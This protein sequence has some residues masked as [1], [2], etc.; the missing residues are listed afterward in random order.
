MD[1]NSSIEKSEP[2][3]VLLESSELL[4]AVGNNV[5]LKFLITNPAPQGDYFKFTLLGI[6]PSWI[7]YPDTPAIWVPAEGHEKVSIS[8]HP[9][10]SIETTPGIYPCR[11]HVFSQSAPEKGV[12]LEVKLHVLQ[13]EKPQTVITIR[14]EITELKAAPGTGVKIP[15][16][17]KNL[18]KLTELMEIS[19]HGVPASWV[20]LLSPV[21]TLYGGEEK[22][23]DVTL[24]IP[25]TPEI[26]PGY[27]PLK[28]TVTSQKD[29]TVRADAGVKLGIAA[30]ESHGRIGVMLNSIQFSLMPGGILT[31]PITLL[32]HGLERDSFRLGV[33]GLPVSWVSIS[34]PVISLE[35][36][37]NKESNLVIRPP[38]SASIQAGRNKFQIIVSSQKAPDQIVRVDCTLTVAAYMKF[39]AELEP[40]EADAS[41]LI[42]VNVKNQGN[43]QQVFNIS[44]LSQNDQLVFEFQPPLK[45]VAPGAVG[46]LNNNIPSGSQPGTRENSQANP[47]QRTAGGQG[48]EYNVLR[49]PAGDS[50]A[51]RFTAR[52]R[53]RPWFGGSV[54]YPYQVRVKSQQGEAPPMPGQVNS[55]GIIPIWILP[56][57]AVLC[58]VIFIATIFGFR[59]GAKTGS[60]TQT[61]AAEST[62][63]AGVTQTIAANQ[64][65]AAIAGQLDTDGDGLTDQRETQLNTN[66][67]NPDTDGDRSWDG[68]EVQIGT[69]P[70]IPDTDADGLLDGL[71]ILPC[72]S[73]LNPDT[74]QDGIIDSKDL[75][76]CDANN[77]A[78]TA[79]A[80][81]LLPTNTPIPTTAIPTQTP[82]ILTPSPTS[83]S[84]PRFGGVILFESDR[85]GNSEVYTLDDS[86]HVGR[87]TDN[88]AA[89]TQAVW[90]ASMQRIAFTTNRDGQNEIYLMNA[91]G[92][93][94]VNLTNNPADDQQPAWSVDGQWIA[95]T[96]NRDG[97]YEIYIL[98]VSDLGTT[99]LSNHPG[100][101]SQPNW[102][103]STTFDPSGEY[104]LFS[105]DR[106]GNL[107]I[108]RMK[109]DGSE[110]VNLSV[111]PAGDQMAKGSPDGALVVFSSDRDGN[112]EV[113]SMRI[114]G[115]GQ[116]NQTNYF[117]YDYQPSWAPNQAW[118]AFTTN[119]DGNNE[120]YILKPGTSEIYNLTS[121]PYQD[122]LTD[123]R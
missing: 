86:G 109:T 90:D 48:A 23:V 59:D 33:E 2:F 75:D 56:L 108:Y 96:S 8:L 26:H 117:S 85:D 103:R 28:I 121:N 93:N 7:T 16:I 58:I 88:P 120:V 50:A 97:N 63:V 115:K 74:D 91:D 100:N 19:V 60:A 5:E 118:I 27:Y 54:S 67:F 11:L 24:Q 25:A 52:P 4:I 81:S 31:I 112:P 84:L 36:G 57:V 82:V 17:V 9:P 105:S 51:F 80:I 122:Q 34:M 106:D 3:T 110:P 87:L 65:A 14:S 68:V 116:G 89:D 40:R 70:L 111:N 123:W 21:A 18:S 107:E 32:N 55:R 22:K 29:P 43:T 104:I 53:Q 78:L 92:S 94:P 114:D 119:R 72:P 35:P 102:V 64:T 1:I 47:T 101:D 13:P 46:S 6:P 98:R 77:P 20:S 66:A 76:P 45:L 69:N 10:A 61:A 15:I 83:V 41:Q 113:Y 37:D 38:H 73:P 62:M 49:I 99:N 44:C 30:F 95:F 71:E 42:S 79:T 39:S 12:E